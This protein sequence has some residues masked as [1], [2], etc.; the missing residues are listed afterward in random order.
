M[1]RDKPFTPVDFGVAPLVLA[2]TG[3]IVTLV[4]GFLIF[5]TRWPPLAI[6]LLG[7]LAAGVGSTILVWFSAA[8]QR[9]RDGQGWPRTIFGAMKDSANWLLLWLP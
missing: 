4:S 3:G 1:R 7:G 6:G 2:L 5:L 9:R 8:A